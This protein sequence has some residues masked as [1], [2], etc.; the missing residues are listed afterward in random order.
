MRSKE[1]LEKEKHNEM[2]IPE[3]LFKEPIE[4]KTKELYNPKTLKQTA[5]ENI[6]LDDK[7]L[8]KEIA[9]KKMINPYYF[10]DS[11][12]QVGFNITL[13]SHHNNHASFKLTIKANFPEFGNEVRYNNKI[14]RE[15]S[16]FYARL[17][18]QYN[19]KQQTVFLARFDKQDEDN[20]VLDGTEL[21]INLNI[22]HNLDETDL[23][24]VDFKSS[25]EH[26]IQQQEK[27]VFGW[28][29]D[30]IN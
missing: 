25:L 3:W 9:K 24:N 12:L 18:N 28:R 27:K 8:N 30:K 17:R 10:T 20:Q 4:N 19:I 22:N 13:E 11:E 29:F 23:D 2:I 14:V 15:L 16:V 5:I 6:K 1:H 26:Q 21:L 7:Q